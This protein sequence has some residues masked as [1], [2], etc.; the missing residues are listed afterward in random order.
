MSRKSKLNAM[1]HSSDKDKEPPHTGTSS[2]VAV[3]QLCSSPSSLPFPSTDTT[4][5]RK[6]INMIARSS[7][8]VRDSKD[9]PKVIKAPDL[10]V[11][12][13]RK[14]SKDIKDS[15][16]DRSDADVGPEVQLL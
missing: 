13:G 16:N 10:I 2:T 11:P 12:K 14:T 5:S 9:P 1:D 6:T 4:A 7:R 8:P 3:I 15:S